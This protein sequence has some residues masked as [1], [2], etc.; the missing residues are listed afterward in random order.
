MDQGVDRVL[1]VLH[2]I[3]SVNAGI[4]MGDVL[5]GGVRSVCDWAGCGIR[6]QEE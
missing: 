3:W 5:G 6:S 1:F 2:V 4:E